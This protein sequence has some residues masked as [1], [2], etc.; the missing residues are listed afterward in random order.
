MT[1]YKL[2]VMEEYEVEVDASEVPSGCDTNEYFNDCYNS[3][4]Y[5][6]RMRFITGHINNVT[7][8]KE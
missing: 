8:V 4:R 5:A 3:D 7:E 2:Q 6:Y 1:K